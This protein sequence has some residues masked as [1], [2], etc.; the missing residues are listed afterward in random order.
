MTTIK[1]IAKLAGISHGTVSNVLNKKGNVSVE[2]IMLVENAAKTLGYKINAQ[3][4]QLRQGHNKC[5][6]VI[7]PDFNMKAYIDLF[8]SIDNLL[9]EY[10]YEVNIYSTNNTSRSEERVLE[11]VIS[12]NP[13]YVIVISS[14]LENSGNYDNNTKFIFVDRFVENMPKNSIFISFDFEK[15]G[16]EIANRLMEDGHKNIALFSDV[17]KFSNEKQFVKSFSETLE[18]KDC[19][20]KVFSSE[21][22]LGASVAF[23]V[24]SS[25][26]YFDC[27]VTTSIERTT[28]LKAAQDYNPQQKL[29]P[30]YSVSSTETLASCDVIKYE[31]NYRL[32][33]KK[34]GQYIL[35]SEKNKIIS[36]K[37]FHVSNDG[38]RFQ[39]PNISAD[40]QKRELN[41]LTL[42]SPNTEALKKLLPSCKQATGID[43]KLTDLP[44]D[45]LYKTATAMTR[46]SGYD[47]IRL[48]MAW[49]SELGEKL[50]LPLDID[51]P[52]I[53]GLLKS[54]SPSISDDYYKIDD[55]VYSFPFDPSVQI[56]YYRKDLFEDAKIKREFY[57]K[58]KL[59]FRVP[60]NFEE[61]NKVAKFFTRKFNKNSPTD[62]GTNLVFGSAAVA[63]CDFLPRFKELGGE[64]FDENGNVIINIEIA[65]KALQSY[66][67]TYDYTDGA[68]NMWWQKA[69]ET[70]AEGNTAMIIVFSNHSSHM[71]HSKSSKV[72]GKIGFAPVPGGYPLLGGGIIGI[73]KDSK[74]YQESI[75]FLKWIYSDKIS[76]AITYLGGFSP[77]KDIYNN[78]DVMTLYPWIEGMDKSFR[79]GGRRNKNSK[80]PKFDDRKFEG[81]L[82]I[83]IR[84]SV[85]GIL[86]IDIALNNAQQLCDKE[87]NF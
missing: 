47:L 1:D 59:Q 77:C 60:Q 18:G 9:K 22:S 69:L 11:R 2:K 25:A 28:Y 57:E 53:Q 30:I 61:Y 66:I 85:T 21:Y 29:P 19:N 79:Y 68:T 51:A 70:F 44:Y 17:N 42:S 38:F 5:V 6:S 45:E 86:D 14:F 75:E 10:G 48:D 31:L 4:K 82:G 46:N 80:H 49:L 13:N 52:E 64:I 34:I 54:F 36:E 23:D 78:E 84:S 67:E 16:M 72:V 76:S 74:K 58:N 55:K 63:A 81:I 40:G 71:L 26:N 27:V 15:A 32:L 24:I 39:F 50:Y 87:F 83:A 62:Y 33:G 41:I 43:V 56:L 3:A 12:L 7:I 35:K 65:K 8:I 73:S 37:K 20:L